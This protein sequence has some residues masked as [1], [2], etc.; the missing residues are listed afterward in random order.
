MTKRIELF[1]VILFSLVSAAT[2]AA[3]LE[4]VSCNS[5]DPGHG[6]SQRATIKL[7]VDDAGKLIGRSGPLGGTLDSY[8]ETKIK[9][10]EPVGSGFDGVLRDINSIRDTGINPNDV[11]QVQ[12]IFIT[13]NSDFPTALHKLFDANGVAIGWLTQFGAFVSGCY[14]N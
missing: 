6:N 9:P 3:E 7:S 5:G 14:P 10:I 12:Y 13:G 1:T 11:K 2:W 8:F 4:I